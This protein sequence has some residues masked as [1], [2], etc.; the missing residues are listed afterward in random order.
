MPWDDWDSFWTGVGF[1]GLG[2][3]CLGLAL[4]R[5]PGE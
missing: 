2:L 5:W 3:V 4:A 1:I